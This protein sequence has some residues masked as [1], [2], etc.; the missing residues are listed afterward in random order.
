MINKGVFCCCVGGTC[1]SHSRP[2]ATQAGAQIGIRVVSS[3]VPESSGTVDGEK[4]AREQGE[5]P[6]A[7][8]S[9]DL[10]MIMMLEQSFLERV[11]SLV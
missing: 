9:I 6:Q 10:D 5:T 2:R 7:G 3:W 4:S 11:Q 8:V 1:E